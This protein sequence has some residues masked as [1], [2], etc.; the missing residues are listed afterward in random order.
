MAAIGATIGAIGSLLS[1]QQQNANSVYD[2]NSTNQQLQ[3]APQPNTIQAVKDIY[4][5]FKNKAD[6]KAEE[7]VSSDKECKDV[8]ETGLKAMDCYRN[9][10]SYLFKYKPEIIKEQEGIQGVDDRP[11]L[12]IIAQEVEQNIP[13]VVSDDPATGHKV[14]NTGHL[15]MANTSAIGEMVRKIDKI[16]EA[17]GIKEDE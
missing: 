15:T 17:L 10:G 3:Q 16:Y 4:D 1:Q 2:N 6:V 11:H 9:I 13:G 5:A 8:K 7:N 14:V 12:G